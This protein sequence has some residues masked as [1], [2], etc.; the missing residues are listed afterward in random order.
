MKFIKVKKSIFGML[1]LIG[2]LLR[3]DVSHSMELQLSPPNKTK[4]QKPRSGLN[5]FCI[6]T[7]NPLVFQSIRKN[8]FHE[9]PK[10]TESQQENRLKAHTN[11]FAPYFN[12]GASVA[13]AR[14]VPEF[15]E[16]MLPQLLPEKYLWA[17]AVVPPVIKYGAY[18]LGAHFLLKNGLGINYSNCIDAEYL[19][20][21]ALTT[22]KALPL[23]ACH[24]V[25]SKA[26][27]A[28]GCQMA[29][30]YLDAGIADSVE[31][32]LE[33]ATIATGAL[34]T[35]CLINRSFIPATL[36]HPQV[37]KLATD[38]CLHYASSYLSKRQIELA[39][40][41]VPLGLMAFGAAGTFYLVNKNIFNNQLLK[42]V[43]RIYKDIRPYS[44]LIPL[45]ISYNADAVK[46]Y[47][48]KSIPDTVGNN[49]HSDIGSGVKAG[50]YWSGIGVAAYLFISQTLGLANQ[51]DVQKNIKKLLN[52]FA[53]I[54]E[55]LTTVEKRLDT[56]VN[57]SETIIKKQNDQNAALEK[58]N[59][60]MND[61]IGDIAKIFKETSAQQIKI[62]AALKALE[63]CNE[64]LH[65]EVQ[66]I[67]YILSEVAKNLA[68]LKAEHAQQL[69]NFKS[70]KIAQEE[71]ILQLIAENDKKVEAKIAQIETALTNQANQLDQLQPQLEELL[72]LIRSENQSYSLDEQTIFKINRKLTE[73]SSNIDE[74]AKIIG[75]IYQQLETAGNDEN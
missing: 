62:N 12:A 55:R 9:E 66:N 20:Q 69:Q 23:A 28:Y 1:L 45:A 35:A 39:D 64:N 57:S 46:D 19:K 37:A 40:N 59:E 30:Q 14:Y 22:S 17:N 70:H 60:E 50:V 43:K 63:Q 24:P 36:C 5:S 38:C 52:K 71:E 16:K 54:K 67:A 47:V 65:G 51:H 31:Q 58:S 21:A 3:F 68:I 53:Q 41:Y 32:Y 33:P 2:C 72:K 4:A 6:P 10:E 74:I 29:H 49:L 42:K 75:T 26:L 7:I 27:T 48:M 11:L 73:N 13:V 15:A 34:A 18:G 8:G 44:F 61:I 56:A 25:V